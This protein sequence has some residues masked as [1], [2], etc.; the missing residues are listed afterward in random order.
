MAYLPSLSLLKTATPK[1]AFAS[2]SS[3]TTTTVISSPE[4]LEQKF[5]RKGIRFSESVDINP[6]VELTVRNGSSLKLHIPS[7]HITSY[8]PKVYWKDEGCEEVLHT[9]AGSGSA[10]S[11]RGGIGLVINEASPEPNSKGSAPKTCEWTV[12]DV[13]SDSTD[14][15]QVELSC[16]RGTLDITYVV[17]LYPLSMATAV[18]V[19]NNGRKPVNLTSAILSHFK[20][21]K[22]SGAG[23]QGLKGCSYCTHPPLSSPFE[24]LSP[25]EAIKSED[26]GFFS[27][28]WEPEN[29][30][31]AWTVQDV[32]ITVLK[33][34]LSR[35]YGAPPGERSKVFHR[36]TPSKY[37]T[38]DQGRGLFFR[39]IRMG[40]DEIHLSSA[41]SYSD[42]YGKDYFICTGPA[43]MLVPVTVKPGG[44]W[45]GAQIIE[46]D[47]L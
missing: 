24:I 21:K 9:L 32:P 8:K 42:K 10:S 46:H 39:V 6:T 35:V 11:S 13:D 36:S 19:K 41:G 20:F 23:I 30:P 34:K 17:S 45:R 25:S 44:E 47:N 4:A 7:G 38:V 27:F 40:Y 37:E 15:L 33:H 14:A 43:S 5:G 12:K 16:I 26:P 28:G 22:R 1:A 18:I 3:L 31:G 29:K 2:A